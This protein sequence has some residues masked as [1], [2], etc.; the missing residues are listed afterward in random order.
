MTRD[1]LYQFL[2]AASTILSL[3]IN[4]AAAAPVKLSGKVK[5]GSG[6]SLLLISKAGE[7]K[8]AALPASG[9]FNFSTTSAFMKNATLQLLSP[10]GRFYGPVVLNRSG[11]RLSTKFSGKAAPGSRKVALGQL[12]LKDGYAVVKNPA[13]RAT[14]NLKSTV[15]GTNGAPKGSAKS[16]LVDMTPSSSQRATAFALSDAGEDQDRDGI[17]NAFDV[18]DDGDRNI[19]SSDRDS[20]ATTAGEN[21][22]TTLFLGIPQTVNANVGGG[23][24]ASIVDSLV[25]GENVLNL[26]IFASLA[27]ESQGSVTGAHVRCSSSN[28]YCRSTADGG[29][30]AIYSGVSGSSGPQL[31]NRW[32]DFN[33]DGS[34]FPN[35]ES[36]SGGANFVAGIQPRTTAANFQAGDVYQV[37]LV[38]GSTVVSSKTLVLAPYFVS[39]PAIQSYDAGSGAVMLDYAVGNSVVGATS[40]NPIVLSSSGELS[41]TFWKPQ[42]Q[43]IAGAESGSFQDM[44]YLHYGIGSGESTCGGFYT[45]P[46]GSTL[47]ESSDYLGEGNSPLAQNGADL[48]NLTD[49]AGDTVTVASNTLTVSVNLKNCLARAGRPSGVTTITLTA[50]GEPLS[51]GTNRAAQ[52]F[53]VNVP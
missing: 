52:T 48:F 43:S 42:R 33:N 9:A 8:R 5:N 53:Y 40:N 13:N 37:E 17:I 16:G 47:S 25:S 23:L 32:T 4:T 41:L 30:T 14:I 29:G 50:A 20:A 2:L 7:V 36:F 12:T 10:A 19:D 3:A 21:P 11:R 35:L 24:S 26:I 51:G 18:D 46:V 31:N 49:S 1:L 39:V 28:L 27:P 44:G 15:A 22:F 38:N 34:G 6:Y 45:I